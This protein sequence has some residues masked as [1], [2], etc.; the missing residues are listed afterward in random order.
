M[1][2][3]AIGLALVWITA[4]GFA[5]AQDDD[6]VSLSAFTIAS[7]A[8]IAAKVPAKPEVAIT[9]RKPATSLEVEVNV[10]N[11]SDRPEVRNRDIYATLTALERAVR[12]TPNLKFARR[13]IQLRGDARKGS[14][15]SR[16]GAV[17]S[18]AVCA[19]VAPIE[20]DTDVFALVHRI[21]ELIAS[22]SPVGVTKVLDS[23]VGLTIDH[24]EQYRQEIIKKVFD[25]LAFVKSLAGPDFEVL[26]SGFTGPVHVRAVSEKEVEL[27]IDYT[28][29]IRSVIE[30]KNPAPRR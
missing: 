15:L 21:R 7:D 12:G 14:I 18:N 13:E 23:S 22:V 29:S 27:W 5:R 8:D 19:V 25:D 20:S 11:G 4:I 2:T 24:P 10:V 3:R 1:N 6:T 16:S 26:P 17:V 28:F 30:L 9:L